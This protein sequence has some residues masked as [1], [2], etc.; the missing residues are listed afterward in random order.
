MEQGKLVLDELLQAEA[1]GTAP[2]TPDRVAGCG[3]TEMP[4][5]VSRLESSSELIGEHQG[6]GERKKLKCSPLQLLLNASD[7]EMAAAVALCSLQALSPRSEGSA[8]QSSD[9]RVT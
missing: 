6:Q 9:N 8:T 2:E 3:R 1:T 7:D 5:A 4:M